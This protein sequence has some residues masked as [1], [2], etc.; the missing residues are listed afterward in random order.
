MRETGMMSCLHAALEAE[1]NIVND[2]I[3]GEVGASSA[4]EMQGFSFP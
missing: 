2:E 4:A 1:V 3:S